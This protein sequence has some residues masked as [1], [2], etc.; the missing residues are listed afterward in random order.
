MQRGLSAI[1]SLPRRSAVVGFLITGLTCFSHADSGVVD[2]SSWVFYS[3]KTQLGTDF[4]SVSAATTKGPTGNVSIKQLANDKSIKITLYS[5]TWRFPVG[6]SVPVTLDFSDQQPLL[7]KGYGDGKFLDIALPTDAV[8]IFLSLIGERSRMRLLVGGSAH[9]L[10]A[11]SLAGIKSELKAFAS[12]SLT[13]DKGAAID[14]KSPAAQTLGSCKDIRFTGL[15]AIDPGALDMA[16]SA[17][18]PEDYVARNPILC[19]KSYVCRGLG[20]FKNQRATLMNEHGDYAYIVTSVD[21]NTG[22]RDLH[23]VIFRADAKCD[24]K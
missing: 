3:G 11:V 24:G 21:F 9:Q 2:F 6:A 7:L 23:L 8:A 22:R 4:C 1:I 18:D 16:S 14:K 20:Y 13:K 12:C 5:T 17:N 15:A 10:W 19:S